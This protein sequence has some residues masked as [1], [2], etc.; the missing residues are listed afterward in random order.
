VRY[1]LQ[2]LK[3]RA[4]TAV[5]KLPLPPADARM[6][7][8]VAGGHYTN[9]LDSLKTIS[10]DLAQSGFNVTI[11][12]YGPK[13]KLSAQTLGLDVD[14]DEASTDGLTYCD[15]FTLTQNDVFPARLGKWLLLSRRV[16]IDMLC[17]SLY[18][19]VAIPSSVTEILN[20]QAERYF[21]ADIPQLLFNYYIYL[22]FLEKTHP[23]VV[24]LCP[25]RP[26]E[27]MLL[28]A[29]C[30]MLEIK[31]VTFDA[32]ILESSY[33]RNLSIYADSAFVIAQYYADHYANYFRVTPEAIHVV[34]SL[35]MGTMLE[36]LQ[37]QTRTSAQLELGWTD[38]SK[39]TVLLIG[40]PVAWRTLAP[41]V[42]MFAHA[43][44]MIEN[45]PRICL[46]LHREE[47]AERYEQ[48]LEIFRKRGMAD[49]VFNGNGEIGLLILASDC[50][51]GFFSTAL[52]EAAAA[53]R[54][55]IVIQP[56]AKQWIVDWSL[57]GLAHSARSW[58]EIYETLCRILENPD[59]MAHESANEGTDA[60]MQRIRAAMNYVITSGK[61]RAEFTAPSD[62]FVRY[63]MPLWI[64]G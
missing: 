29:A 8:H 59:A 37:G 38:S 26:K 64:V 46:R 62:I 33:A 6:K 60:V 15:L 48:Y 47:S 41:C 16:A 7:V 18:S 40:Q 63:H 39:A 42:D 45:C 14:S 35:R 28:A 43:L 53:G 27:A 54:P 58:R 1:F 23:S 32:H 4:V 31:T 17:S 44:S 19:D 12:D 34:G 56:E 55:V 2:C 9:Y 57:M 61:R 36:S 24:L 20:A 13:P 10:Q 22:A 50:V 21:S 51:A 30:H 25:S 49:Q 5:S 52:I 11:C 3:N